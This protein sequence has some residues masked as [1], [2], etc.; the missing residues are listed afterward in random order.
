MLYE[1]EPRLSQMAEVSAAHARATR[2]VCVVRQPAGPVHLLTAA[3]FSIQGGMGAGKSLEAVRLHKLARLQPP[4][5]APAPSAASTSAEAVQRLEAS[6]Q[7]HL[8]HSQTVP[9]GDTGTL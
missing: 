1:S 6:L 4:G 2:T 7:L 5:L 9:A 8:R 3:L